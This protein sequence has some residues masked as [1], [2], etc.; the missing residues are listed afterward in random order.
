MFTNKLFAFAA[1]GVLATAGL[2]QAQEQ[3]EVTF[4]E[5]SPGSWDVLAEV[6]SDNNSG[7]SSYDVSVVGTPATD[8]SYTQNTLDTTKG[9][10]SSVGFAA[11]SMGVIGDEATSTHFNAGSF[12]NPV[13]STKAPVFDIGK[14]PVMV[15]S[16]LPGVI[17][18]IDLDVPALLGTFTTPEGLGEANFQATAPGLFNAAADGFYQGDTNLTTTVNPIPEP[19]SLALLGLGGVAL[20]ARRKRA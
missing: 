13:G 20:L 6:T 10:G 7:L 5:T 14:A 15:E 16:A 19:T 17:E 8:I 18:S 12:Q 3:I 2:A 1:A 11:A 9:D 4:D